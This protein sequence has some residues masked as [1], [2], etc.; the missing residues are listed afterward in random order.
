MV[1]VGLGSGAL[2]CASRPL[3]VRL[4]A[5]TVRDIK[6]LQIEKVSHLSVSGHRTFDPYRDDASRVSQFRVSTVPR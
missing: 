5:A 2:G 3:A 6:L 4:P 1:P